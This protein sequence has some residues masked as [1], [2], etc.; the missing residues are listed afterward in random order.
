MNAFSNVK[1]QHFIFQHIVQIYVNTYWYTP[2]TPYE[3]RDCCDRCTRRQ[4]NTSARSF[5]ISK[6][7]SFTSKLLTPNMYCWS[8]KTLVTI[9]WT[10]LRVN[11]IWE[12]SFCPQKMNN[13]TLFLLRDAFSGS[14]AMFIVYKWRYIDVVVINSQLLLIIKLRTK[15]VFLIFH[16]LKINRI[17]PFCNL[18]IGWPSY[19]VS[20]R[21]VWTDFT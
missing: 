14:V 21:W 1:H 6:A 9:Y 5:F 18:F 2:V 10:H 17:M 11:G 20:V 16:I 15:P 7:F 19:I 3:R 12:K 4:N 13:R 8:C